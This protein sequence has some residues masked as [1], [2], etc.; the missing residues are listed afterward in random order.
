MKRQTVKLLILMILA[1]TI[2][3][4]CASC[5]HEHAYGE[6]TV[7]MSPG[8]LENGIEYRVCECGEKDTREI[9]ALGH[10]SGEWV[11]DEA[12]TCTEDGHKYQACTACDAVLKTETISKLGHK[13]GE[14]AEAT[15]PTCTV[16]GT[17]KRECVCGETETRAVA[18][19]GHTY[20]S[21]VTPPTKAEDGYTTHTC[22]CGYSF[23]DSY[24]DA[25]G[26]EGLA[27]KVNEDGKTCTITGI[28]GF[29]GTDLVIPETIDGYTVTVI[30]EGAFE[31]HTELVSVTIPATI[32]KS[33][34]G[35]Y[36]C[37]NLKDVYITDI[38]AW[39]RIEFEYLSGNPLFHAS[40]L[41]LNGTL[42]TELVIPEG[43]TSIGENA[44][45]NYKH[46]KKMVV[47]KSVKSIGDYAFYE[48]WGI[49][50]IYYCSDA[51]DWNCEMTRGTF[52]F[53][54]LHADKYFY[55]ETQPTDSGNYWHYVGGVL[56]IWDN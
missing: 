44:F 47:P 38:A 26:F 46:L 51:G 5:G 39:M 40:N 10:N 16:D 33:P 13:F 25:L 14:W 45:Y 18:A 32:Q 43:T 30:G 52:N 7:E 23:I 21:V 12:A 11:T 55:S 34:D 56:T 27:Y 37:T 3:V 42:L 9:K 22:A 4:L 29:K 41:Y 50:E 54:L 28:G 15:A 53:P 35:F 49:K 48:C 31:G 17:E 20:T 19:T 24:V 36:G 6:W 1:L 2:A 8:C